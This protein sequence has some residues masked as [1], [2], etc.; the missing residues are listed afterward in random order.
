MSVKTTAPVG[1]ASKSTTVSVK[2][3]EKLKGSATGTAPQVGSKPGSAVP[4]Y[5]GT[6]VKG[7]KIKV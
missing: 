5:S 7:G 1:T 2:G 3:I 6:A 4:G